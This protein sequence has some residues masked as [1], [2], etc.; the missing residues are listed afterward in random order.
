MLVMHKW[1]A[2]YWPPEARKLQWQERRQITRARK[3]D[4]KQYYSEH[5]RPLHKDRNRVPDR[6]PP[7]LTISL[8][9]P[10]VH[11]GEVC[12]Q[13]SS[14]VRRSSRK[15]DQTK[16]I[17]LMMHGLQ[18]QQQQMLH[19]LQLQLQ[20]GTEGAMGRQLEA[21]LADC[22]SPCVCGSGSPSPAAT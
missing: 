14:S 16:E 4:R 12:H 17:L 7:P 8:I 15:D 10:G 19:E 5:G 1:G 2:E 18:R 13:P 6:G 11:P 21:A 22:A 3:E 9:D 20:P